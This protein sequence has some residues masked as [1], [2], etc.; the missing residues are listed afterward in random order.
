MIRENARSIGTGPKS[1]VSFSYRPRSG[2]GDGLVAD[3]VDGRRRLHRASPVAAGSIEIR[4]VMNA[5]QHCA[6]LRRR[7]RTGRRRGHIVKW[8]KL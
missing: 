6:P 3:G 1:A 8:D 4:R 2:K 7:L 5:L